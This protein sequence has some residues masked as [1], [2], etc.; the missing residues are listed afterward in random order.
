M[1]RRA[2]CIPSTDRFFHDAAAAALETID[3]TVTPDRIERVLCD[4]L[5]DRYPNVDVHRQDE[6]GRVLDEEVWYVYR[7]GRPHHGTAADPN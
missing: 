7:D 3:G 5:V 1:S 2:S 6:L 4:L